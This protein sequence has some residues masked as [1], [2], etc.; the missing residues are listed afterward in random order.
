[1][2]IVCVN[3][4]VYGYQSCRYTSFSLLN[5]W[6]DSLCVLYKVD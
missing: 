6:G 3:E 5:G 4:T 2:Y 1:M